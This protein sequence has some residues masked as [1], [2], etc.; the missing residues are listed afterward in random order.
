MRIE[1][2]RLEAVEFMPAQLEPAVLYV[3][4][5]YRTAAHLC[6]CGCGEKVRTQLGDLGWHLTTGRHGPTLY[7]S[8][9]NWQKPCRSH[10]FIR[11]GR[12]IWQGAWTESEVL[13]GR[14]VE[15][16]RRDAY[17]RPLTE[18]QWLRLKRWLKLWVSRSR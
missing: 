6:A 4:E 10:Y 13:E 11:D 12:V 16:M 15:E 1:R 17:F 7:P 5:K 2:I 9:G 3:S 18:G 14:R 8:I